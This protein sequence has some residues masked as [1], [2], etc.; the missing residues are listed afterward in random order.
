MTL[1]WNV[2]TKNSEEADASAMELMVSPQTATTSGLKY[3]DD[4]GNLEVDGLKELYRYLF[5]TGIT[6]S[7]T[8]WVNFRELAPAWELNGE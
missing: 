5:A 4:G 7:T 3:S 1:T 8:E 2:Q 6:A